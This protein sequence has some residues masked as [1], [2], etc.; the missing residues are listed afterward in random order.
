MASALS[1]SAPWRR[2][3]PWPRTGERERHVVLEADAATRGRIAAWLE[4]ESVEHV[5]LDV[6]LR[7]WL[8]GMRVVGELDAVVGRVCG[9]SLEPYEEKVREPVDL[10]LA[11]PG[12][13]NLPGEGDAEVLVDMETEDPPESGDV[14]GADLG[15]LAVEALSLGLPPF[16]RKP[17]AAFEAPPDA[18]E[19]SPF[20]TL[21][22][23]VKRP[24]NE[25]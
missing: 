7:P 13:R 18:G 24:P 16:A 20:A 22:S 9:V 14:E 19:I 4:L 10:R 6:V 1:D 15:L 21:A 17:G 3:E 8:D 25:R 2:I 11:P 5:V 23:L 12:S